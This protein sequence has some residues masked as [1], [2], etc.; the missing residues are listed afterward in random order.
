MGT[1]KTPRA[2]SAVLFSGRLRA[3]VE[4]AVAGGGPATFEGCPLCQ[5]TQPLDR[6]IFFSGTAAVLL[7]GAGMTDQ[8]QPSPRWWHRY[9]RFGVAPT[10]RAGAR[11]WRRTRLDRPKHRDQSAAVKA[12]KAAGGDISYDWEWKDG[13]FLPDGG[14]VVAQVAFEADRRRI[15]HLGGSRR[16]FSEVHRQRIGS[17]RPSQE[18]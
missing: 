1:G 12:I 6:L 9:L 8:P 18:G 5:F 11:D 4:A 3:R 2:R 14:A 10:D 13:H 7:Q 15:L 17:R 16:H